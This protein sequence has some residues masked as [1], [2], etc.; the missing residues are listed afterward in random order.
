[1]K[2]MLLSIQTTSRSSKKGRVEVSILLELGR[3]RTGRAQGSCLD[4]STQILNMRE[5]K[6]PVSW[7]PSMGPT[8]NP[9]E[10]EQDVRT[11]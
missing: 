7:H 8:P 6:D 11:D 4:R 10:G 9:V 3:D 5:M 2:R 1:M